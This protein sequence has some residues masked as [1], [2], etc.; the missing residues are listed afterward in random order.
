VFGNFDAATNYNGRLQ[1]KISRK[2][3][4]LDSLSYTRTTDEH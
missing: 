3:V 4:F 2:S 1:Y